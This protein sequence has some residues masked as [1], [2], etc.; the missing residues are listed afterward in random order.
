MAL[1]LFLAAAVCLVLSVVLGPGQES[2]FLHGVH[3]LAQW[4]GPLFLAVGVAALF[5]RRASSWVR[6]RLIE[7][8]G[9]A[10]ISAMPPRTVLNST[11]ERVLGKKVGHRE[12]I[13]A[14]MGG[15]GRDPAARDTAASRSTS[16]N[17]RFERIDTANLLSEIA[18]SHDFTGVRDNH[19]YVL[20]ATTDAEILT[21]INGERTY[22]LFESWR[23]D[24]E[25]QLANF[26]PS[27]KAELDVGV[28]YRDADDRLHVVD[29]KPVA[30]EEV[31]LND[32]GQFVR[33]PRSVDPQNLVIFHLDLH[34]LTDPDHVVGSIE[35]LNLRTSTV[36]SFDQGYLSWT[37][38]HP[39]FV[40]RVV[41]DVRQLAQ[42]D[43]ILAFQVIVA[44]LKRPDIPFRGTWTRAADRIEVPI[45]SWM[46]TGHGVTLLWRPITGR[47]PDGSHHGW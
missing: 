15:S 47:E 18:W 23:L 39:C 13:T 35:R 36:G 9:P 12:V 29:P 30:G 24:N 32:Y 19:H 45:D 38:P 41:F 2:L 44:T 11:L 20:F 14:L 1:V 10:I 3:V 42:G 8:A 28:T 43:E 25:E 7:L 17:V 33:L 5:R 21:A 22:P 26:V 40:E 16:A 37:V 6:H 4:I 46:L 27:M 31:A 34:D